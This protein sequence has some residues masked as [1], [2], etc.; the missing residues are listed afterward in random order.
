[1]HLSLSTRQPDIIALIVASAC[2]MENL[3]ATVI[4]T[5]LPHLG[6]TFGVTPVNL[7]V[8]FISTCFIWRWIFL[9]NVPISLLGLA[10]T[11]AFIPNY[12][13]ST[14]RSFDVPNFVLRGRQ[15]V[16]REIV[17]AR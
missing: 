17:R 10:L 4:A 14:R 6:A 5:A 8:G 13:G 9:L 7:S 15:I 2:F 3:D 12:R 16:I 11:A 1:M